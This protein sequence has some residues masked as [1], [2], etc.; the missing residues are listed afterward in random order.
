MRK[1]VAKTFLE[2]VPIILILIFY[3][4]VIFSNLL[5]SGLSLQGFTAIV[6]F[7]ISIYLWA[8]ELI[9]LPVTAFL[10]ILMLA[11]SGS[12]SLV[13]SLYGLGS[14]VVFL[15]IIGFFLAAGLTRSGLD[16]RIA[17][18]ILRNSHSENAVLIGLI[19]ITGFLSMI[20]SNTTTT[21]LMLPIALHIM[22][23]VRMNN[24]A[25]LLGIAFAANIGGAG[26]LIG[27][28]PNIIASEALGW[29]FYEWMVAALPFALVMLFLLYV[30]FMIY[31]KPKHEKIEK[32]LVS[33]LGPVKKEEK[34]AGLIIIITLLLW[35]T[36]PFHGLPAIVVGLIGGLLMFL[37]VY[38]WRY[39]ERVTSWGTIILI[40]GAVSIGHSLEITGATAW[41][42][43]VFLAFTGLTSPAL[44]VFSFVI[45]VM[46]I[47]Q[48][49]QNTATAA[50]FI[51]VLTGLSSTLGL[52]PQVLVV[53][54][55]IAVSMTFLAPPG[56][57][58]N[59]IVHGI[60]K[61]KTKEMFRAG[62]LPT[63]FALILLFIYCW[64]YVG[65]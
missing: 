36:S 64:F 48:F 19:V 38:N 47:T 65:V 43:N 5:P 4:S 60:G 41:V 39:F 56:T 61:I 22:H 50:M 51:P 18:K 27:T 42:A 45:L 10:A 8:T 6:I 58:P 33:D 29:G 52:P 21:L 16:K 31:F 1:R 9:P 35:I 20:I 59:A 57:A 11:F 7:L 32:T 49:I 26:L 54:V 24:H 63:F 62:L 14:T 34:T 15:I 13:D 53:P 30:S 25:I 12:V 37:F 23:K 17:Y 28:P 46:A 3:V 40:A 55:A 2:I 44:I